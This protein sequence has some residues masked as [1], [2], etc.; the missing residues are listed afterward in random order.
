M[1]STECKV[2]SS[3]ALVINVSNSGTVAVLTNQTSVKRTLTVPAEPG[4]V[5]KTSSLAVVP[6]EHVC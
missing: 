3:S 5:G 6:Q 2:G 4:G 1:S